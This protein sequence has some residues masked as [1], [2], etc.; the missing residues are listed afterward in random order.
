MQQLNN[1]VTGNGEE[2]EDVAKEFLVENGLLGE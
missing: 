2:P 1:R